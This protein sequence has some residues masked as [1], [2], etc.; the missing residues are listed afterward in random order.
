[1]NELEIKEVELKN[2]TFPSYN[3][4]QITDIELNNLKNSIQEFGYIEPIIINTIN[5]HIIGGNQRAKALIELG[6]KTVP[7]I[8]IAIEDPI[9][10][11]ACNVALNKISGEWDEE[12]LMDVL[13][14]I[15][16]SDFNINL[17]GFDNIELNELNIENQ[18]LSDDSLF[19]KDDEIYY[20]PNEEIQQDI[21]DGWVIYDTL[22]EYIANIMDIPTA[23]Y[24]FNRL[25]QGYKDGYNISLLFNPHRLDTPTIKSKSVWYAI[26]EDVKYRETFAKLL[27]STNT[28]KPYPQHYKRI[29]VG[30]RGYQYVNEFPPYIARDIYKTYCKDNDKIL[31]QCAGWGGRL[32]GLASCLFDNIEYWETDPNTKTYNGLLKLKQF[33]RLG[34]NIKQFNQ[35]FEDLKLPADYFDFAF[36]S[37][38]YFDTELYDDGKMTKKK[39]YDNYNKW[40]TEFGYPLIDKTITA[41]KPNG[42]CLLNIGNR[43]YPILDD[44]TKYINEHY[45]YYITYK[46]D[47]NLNKQGLGN[48]ANDNKGEKFILFTKEV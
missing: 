1:M 47:F 21:I 22:E 46:N 28:L 8:H 30:T 37:P 32:I 38:P 31:N 48:R 33:L 24:Q 4:R 5:N 39:E 29:D 20:F 42:K 10:E 18:E 26:N 12:L 11:K 16:L 23:K 44:L 25:C 2:L 14:E 35:P 7:A 40:L 13:N 45:N 6:Y 27:I 3:P 36:T 43:T 15:Q 34:D 9:K 41:L 19:E 17:T